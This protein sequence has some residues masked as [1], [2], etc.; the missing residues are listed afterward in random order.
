MEKI[1]TGPVSPLAPEPEDGQKGKKSC[2]SSGPI[3]LPMAPGPSPIPAAQ[4]DS[5]CDEA[6]CG[7]R[8]GPPASPLEKAGYRIEPFVEDFIDTPAGM[9]PRV[10]TSLSRKDWQGSAAARIGGARDDYRISPGLYAVGQ[11][12]PESEVLVTANYKLS[13]DALRRY[14]G[15]L[16]VWVLVLD[17]RGINVWCA[18]GKKTFSTEEIIKR[19]SLAGLDRVVAHRRLILPQLGATGV[20]AREVK[21]GCGF[22]VVWGPIKSSDIKKFLAYGRKADEGMRRVTFTLGERLV[23]IPVE[24]TLLKKYLLPFFIGIVLPAGLGTGVYSLSRAWDRGWM[25]VA[26]VAAGVLAG[27]ALSPALLPW[28]PSRW[29]SVKGMAAG[30][31]LGIPAAV[32]YWISGGWLNSLALLLLSVTLSSYLA[33]NFTGSTPYTSPTGVEKEMRRAIPLQAAAFLISIAIWVG[34]GFA[35]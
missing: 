34:S 19:A 30:L 22:E 5:A 26:A 6:C 7:H 29:F 18:A 32:L 33:M 11:P 2:C 25:A 13:F 10:K 24:I 16:D 27:T 20:S 28:L 8:P 14:L 9:V 4:D 23:L 35:A 1:Q 3:P 21:K 12:G 17:T 15:D 31:V